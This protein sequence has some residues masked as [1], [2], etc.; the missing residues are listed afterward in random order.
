MKQE[1]FSNT[2][3]ATAAME[4]MRSLGAYGT[5][6]TTDDNPAATAAAIAL[7]R[8]FAKTAA[9]VEAPAS[10][11]TVPSQRGANYP[12]LDELTQPA[13]STAQAAYYLNRRPQTLRGWACA[14][15]WPEGL[16]PVR[17]NGRLAWP[18]AGLCAALGVTPAGAHP[19]LG[20][21][22]ATP[23]PVERLAGNGAS[24]ARQMAQ[25]ATDHHRRRPE[26]RRSLAGDLGVGFTEP[27][28]KKGGA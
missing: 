20:P 17:I 28:A 26:H 6:T 8:S 7:L 18:V 19:E 13:V 25:G 24:F 2:E 14:E 9:V 11:E 22:S 15:T 21:P 1:S 16:R 27:L 10:P 4:V 23:A 3:I 12:P 5:N